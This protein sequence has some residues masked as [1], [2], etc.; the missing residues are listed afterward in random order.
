VL[1]AAPFAAVADG[2]AF[3]ENAAAS[4]EVGVRPTVAGVNLFAFYVISQVLFQLFLRLRPGGANTALINGTK[5]SNGKPLGVSP[6]K[7]SFEDTVRQAAEAAKRTREG[8]KDD[9]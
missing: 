9:R 2:A 4:G 3:F 1:A 6:F 5:T 7:R 8:R